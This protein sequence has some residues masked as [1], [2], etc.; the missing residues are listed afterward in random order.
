[1]SSSFRFSADLIPVA[2]LSSGVIRDRSFKTEELFFSRPIK[3]FDFVLGRFIGGFL[4]TA[5][6]FA[7][8]PLAFLIGSV[9]PWLDQELIGPTRLDWFLYVYLAF[10]LVNMWVVGTILFTVANFTR[11]TMLVW[12]GF[13]GL[14]VLYFVGSAIAGQE[15]ALRETLALIDPFGFNTFGEATRYWTAFEQNSQVVPFE[16]TMLANR[17]L[18][19]GIGLALLV[20]NLVT[21]RF[22]SGK[23][24][25][26]GP[27]GGACHVVGWRCVF[28]RHWWVQR[29]PDCPLLPQKQNHASRE[30]SVMPSFGD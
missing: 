2:F 15:P 30:K 21:F 29:S 14:L 8:V 4:A 3:E 1:M 25:P 11:S 19:I 9:M 26:I 28:Y 12:A 10:G 17:L 18:W 7:S 6:C 20:L 16:G 13:V 5:L 22:R 23:Q 27:I 24:K